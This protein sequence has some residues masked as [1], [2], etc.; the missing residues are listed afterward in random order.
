[1]DDFH[2][3]EDFGAPGL[4]E[5]TSGIIKSSV[6][7]WTSFISVSLVQSLLQK[8]ILVSASETVGPLN[9]CFCFFVPERHDPTK[10]CFFWSREHQLLFF[11]VNRRS[12]NRSQA[13]RIAF[14]RHPSAS[15]SRTPHLRSPA[16]PNPSTSAHFPH[17]RRRIY[18]MSSS[19]NQPFFRRTEKCWVLSPRGG[20][21]SAHNLDSIMIAAQ[22]Q[23]QVRGGRSRDWSLRKA[24]HEMFQQ[25]A[26]ENKP[27]EKDK[28]CKITIKRSASR[29][30][31]LGG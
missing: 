13:D 14:C 15:R 8:Q 26:G 4:Y 12:E 21:R 29:T 1:M 11:S 10:Q 20:K 3:Y 24:S 7:L 31:A 27:A 2:P 23:E 9:D 17:S 30:R 18:E 6:L 22:V 19:R 5:S 25:I 28:R 16:R